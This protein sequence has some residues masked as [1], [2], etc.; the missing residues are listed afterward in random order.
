[1]RNLPMRRYV[2]V[3]TLPCRRYNSGEN[4]MVKRAVQGLVVIGASYVGLKIVSG[5]FGLVIS[6][7][8]FLLPLGV[9]SAIAYGAWQW[10][11]R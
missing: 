11:K 6:M 4:K 10:L 2:P 8:S 7:F 5:V 9:L 3:Y 1:M